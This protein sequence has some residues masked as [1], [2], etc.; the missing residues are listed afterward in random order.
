MLPDNRRITSEQWSLLEKH[1]GDVETC[2]GGKN[3]GF[4]EEAAVKSFS[5]YSVSPCLH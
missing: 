1:K 3:Q 4:S 2:T 5:F